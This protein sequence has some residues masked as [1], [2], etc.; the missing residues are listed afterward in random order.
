MI[1]R[2]SYDVKGK[3]KIKNYSFYG[4]IIVMDLNEEWVY[5]IGFPFLSKRN[6]RNI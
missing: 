5:H 6:A 1:D 3:S 2:S 4:E